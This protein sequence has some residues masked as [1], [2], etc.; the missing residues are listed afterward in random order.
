LEQAYLAALAEHLAAAGGR[1]QPGF[2][3][4][5]ILVAERE[6]GITFPPDLR[7]VLQALLPT[8]QPGDGSRQPRWPNWRDGPRD[9]LVARLAWPWEGIK[10]DLA[11]NDLVVSL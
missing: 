7:Q 9:A 3:D 2:S 6:F 10:F 11:Y 5:E 1:I 4:E 8:D